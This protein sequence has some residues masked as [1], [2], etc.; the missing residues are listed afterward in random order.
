MKVL[1]LTFGTRGDVDPYI[2][3]AARLCVEGHE[4][5]VGAPEEFRR[6]V[7]ACGAGFEPMGTEMLRLVRGSMAEM[8]GPADSVR[9]IARMNQAMKASLLEQWRAAQRVEPTLIVAHPKALGGVHIAQRLRIPVVA[10]IPLPFLT[11]TSD[12]PVPFISRSLTGPVNR[13]SY[14]VNRF[15]AIAYGGMIN[16]FRRQVLG[17]D[18]ITRFSD[19]LH[20]DDGSRLPVLYGFSEHVVPVPA[21]YPGNAH[22]TGYWHRSGSEWTPPVHL[23]EFLHSEDPTVYIGFGS[24]GFGKHAAERGRLLAEAVD[25]AGIRAVVATGWGGVDLQEASPRILTLDEAPHDHLFPRVSAV[26]HHGGAGTTAAGLRAGR[27][28]LV[29]PVLGDQ[30]FWGQRVAALGAGPEPVA[31]RKLTVQVLADRL[32]QLVVDPQFSRQATA[33]GERLRQED[34]TG[35]AVR[36]LE[37]IS[38][39]HG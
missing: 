35:T 17:L 10:S 2:A 34:G 13:A 24:M 26:V 12:F 29:A 6:D 38:T 33:V 16:R 25:R 31:L 37:D 23:A 20:T 28:T 18:R 36:V 9:L 22:V 39:E 21:D 27:P 5:V 32:R 11:P 14:H 1:I 3:L 30:A 4:A 19:Y 7:E 15:S 8:A